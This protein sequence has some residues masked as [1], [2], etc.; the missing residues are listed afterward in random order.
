MAI[1]GEG[2]TIETTNRRG[3]ARAYPATLTV[4]PS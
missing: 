4:I 2:T 3:A 1:K